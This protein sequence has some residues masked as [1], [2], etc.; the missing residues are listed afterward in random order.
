MK[1]REK[2]RVLVLCTGNSCR[3]QMAE[4]WIRHDLG[5]RVEVFSA[6]TMPSGLHPM[7]IRV[8]AEVGIDI[9]TQRSK[10]LS[11]FLGEDFDLVVTVCDS[12]RQ[13][14]PSFPGAVKQVHESIA[15]PVI[16]GTEGE[17]ALREFRKSRDIIHERVVARVREELKTRSN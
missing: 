3:S 17:T 7:A 16:Y 10:P 13:V 6:G 9:S 8:M 12:A 15:D 11:E 1:R 4:G 2:M 5:D 14:C